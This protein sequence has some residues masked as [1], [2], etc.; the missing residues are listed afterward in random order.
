MK[1][2]FTQTSYDRDYFENGK[3][4]GKS[5]YENYRWMPKETIALADFLCL[6]LSF[7]IDDLVLDYGCAKGYLVRALRQIG[8]NAWGY[9]ISHYA[10][11]QA[12]E[13]VKRCVSTQILDAYFDWVIAKD[14]FEHLNEAELACELI[15]LKADKL[16][17]AVP[18]GD[19]EKYI[20]P[21]YEKDPTHVIRQPL[22]WW[23]NMLN[24][25]GWGVMDAEYR[26]GPLK[27]RWV[28]ESPEGN[29]FITARKLV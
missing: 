16:F 13:D 12:P 24:T 6:H 23:C 28:G 21:E 5:L 14:V 4:T 8:V 18:L 27:E 7:T 1:T 9:D 22:E 15:M 25:C 17:M 26:C 19:G 10:I 11:S 20:I 29:G 3:E 2:S